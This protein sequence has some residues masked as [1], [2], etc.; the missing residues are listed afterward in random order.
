MPARIGCQSLERNWHSN[1]VVAILTS[2]SVKSN[3]VLQEI[4]AAWGL[5]KPIIPIVATRDLLNSLPIQLND[6]L[7]LQ[8]E[9]LTTPEGEQQFL[10][11]IEI[12]L[13]DSHVLA[14]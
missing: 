10:K 3:W 12:A 9:D 6:S 11:A 4:G 1:V 14:S 7:A 5:G 13:A 8:L 2:A